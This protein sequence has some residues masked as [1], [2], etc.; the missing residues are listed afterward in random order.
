MRLSLRTAVLTVALL[1]GAASVA[2]AQGA[3]AATVD[4]LRR[5]VAALSA[6]LDSVEANL[7]PAA[8]LPSPAKRQPTGNAAVDSLAATVAVL[9]ARVNAT[10]AARCAPA[11][12]PAPVPAAADTSDP[13][14]AI[15]AAADSAAAAAGAPATPDTAAGPTVFVSRQRNQSSMNPEISATGDVQFAAQTGQEGLDLQLVEVEVSL[16]AAL[17]P[18]SATKIYLTWGAEEIGVEEAYIYWTG[19]PGKVR[20][21][22]GKFRMAVGQLNRWHPHALP[23]TNYPLVYQ[24]FLGEDGLSGVGAGLYTL[25]PVSIAEGTSEVFLQGAAIES[26]PLNNAAYQPALLGRL[27]NFWQ[28]SRSTY[29]ELGFTGLGA[30]DS[31]NDLTS[32]LLGADVRFTIRPPDAGNRKDITWRTEGYRL[33][34]VG[35][36]PTTTRYGMY[37][38]L[39]WKLSQRWI[40]GARYDF[41]EAPFGPEDDT[42]RATAVATWWQSEFVYLRLQAYRNHLESTG[43]LDNLT[44]QVVWAMGPHKHENY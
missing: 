27:A 38:D 34:R 4:S 21:D 42:W 8:P 14:A 2:T 20:A 35:P 6:R 28:L 19:L 10:V 15:R 29:M 30:E 13:L 18:Y 23:E 44:L 3:P 12:A 17:D 33:Q 26:E 11:A 1:G 43:S 32:N 16:Q 31:D 5:T 37:S 22:L 36:D 9:A 25:L 40:L 24:A 7:C 41:V 39:S